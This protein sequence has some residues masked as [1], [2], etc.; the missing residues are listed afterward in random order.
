MMVGW[1]VKAPCLGSWSDG[2]QY[3]RLCYS[4]V[5]ALYASDD[6]DRGL[7]ERRV[8]YLEGENEYPVLTGAVMWLASLPASSP[9]SFFNWNAV[10]LTASALI[11]SWFLYR[12]VGNRALL[13]ALSP[14]LAIYGLINWDL[15]VV[16]LA[17]AAT[18]VY[19]QG[20]DRAAGILVGL[21][22]AA[23]IYPAL[24]IVPFALGRL[25]QDRPADAWRLAATAGLTWAVV[26][27][28]V[29]VL[30]AGRW[31][32]FF[33]FN[34]ARTADWDSLWFI[35]AH[36]LDFT[37]NTQVLNALVAVSFVATVA[38]VWRAA[39]GRPGFQ[40]WT[41]GFPVVAL[42]LLTNKVY[43]PQYGLW[44]L[45]WFALTLP[46]IRLFA[47][48]QAADVAVFIT[49]FQFFAAYEGVGSGLP[50]WMF[51]VAVIIRAAILVACIVAWVRRQGTEHR[52]LLP[53]SEAAPA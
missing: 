26:N 34:S 47:A 48:F 27:L 41:L 22:A 18:F 1:L 30:A 20:R 8:P 44:L 2:R 3:N 5:T 31:S 40:A 29:A 16:A 45:P 51:Q 39:A 4:D 37:W 9:A 17:T 43:S 6:R 12:L 23:K 19:L 7:D 28:P 10:L 46:G 15:V 24:L 50:F 52:E 35:A 11:T 38:I 33:R 25:R 13:F 14:T 36:H 32:E 53:A 42:F 49:R 21:G